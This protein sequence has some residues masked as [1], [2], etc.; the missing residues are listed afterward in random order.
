MRNPYEVLG[1]QR[2]SSLEEIKA[3]YKKLVKKYHPD[4]YANNPLSD[5]AQE[6]LKEINQAYD[7][8]SGKNRGSSGQSRSGGNT[9]YGG[10]QRS[11]TGSQGGVNYGE[12]RMMIERGNISGAESMLNGITNRG[13]EWNYLMGVVY[14]KKGWYDQSY[15]HIS[16]AVQMEPG[17]IEY[18]NAL[19]N[20][21]MR[22]QGYRAY[23]NGGGYRQSSGSCCDVCSCLICTDCCCEC[24]GGDFISCC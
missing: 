24:M 1:V 12:V 17:N 16:L 11:Y 2:E 15:Q 4:Q 6:K 7:E 20:F 8:L 21:N 19:N 18:R 9:G 23:G 22:N 3:A 13:A 14:H 5:L 10:T